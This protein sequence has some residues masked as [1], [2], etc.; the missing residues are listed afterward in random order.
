MKNTYITTDTHF[1]HELLTRLCKRP[2][3]Y[4]A[5]IIKGFEIL[6]AE[7]T[8]IHLGDICMGDVKGVH[9]KIIQKIP[10]KKTLI[11]GN[12]DDKSYNWYMDN[13]WDFVCDRFDAKLYGYKIAFTHKPIP[14]DGEF[15][16]NVHGHLH[17]LPHRADKTNFINALVSLELHGYTPLKLDKFLDKWKKDIWRNHETSN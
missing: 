8:L 7:D 16:V 9:E 4:E 10:C 11:K 5:Q 17:D 14:W 1:N 2:E 3:D 13:G 15:D 6:K 12:H